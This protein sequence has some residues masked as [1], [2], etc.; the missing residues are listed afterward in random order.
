MV[1]QAYIQ[2]NILVNSTNLDVVSVFEY[3][4]NILK[5]TALLIRKYSCSSGKQEI[6]LKSLKREQGYTVASL[7]R[8][9]SQTIEHV[10]WSL[11]F[12]HLKHGQ[13]TKNILD[14]WNIFFKNAP[15]EYSMWNG[16][17]RH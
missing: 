9:T 4:G 3:F 17:A 7:E 12:I 10:Y 2:Q 6:L 15:Y 5:E 1:E 14:F 8:R 11:Y 16:K 13:F